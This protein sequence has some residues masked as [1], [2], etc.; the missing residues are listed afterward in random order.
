MIKSVLALLLNLHATFRPVHLMWDD[1]D[2]PTCG[3]EE[4]LLKENIH[5][6]GNKVNHMY[7]TW[8]GENT[9]SFKAQPDA[10]MSTEIIF[11][12]DR[13]LWYTVRGINKAREACMDTVYMKKKI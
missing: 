3:A 10:Y 6:D 13:S 11:V 5:I 8:T 9:L 7:W 4:R 1:S 2:V 12:G